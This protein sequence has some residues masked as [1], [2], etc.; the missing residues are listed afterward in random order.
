MP[1]LL[2]FRCRVTLHG[3]CAGVGWL[4]LLASS[5]H[6]LPCCPN[7]HAVCCLL[8]PTQ[9]SLGA[10]APWGGIV[11]LLLALLESYR[12]AALWGVEDAEQRIYPGQRTAA[13]L[14][15]LLLRCLFSCPLF[16]CPL[17]PLP[18]A[19]KSTSCCSP[20]PRP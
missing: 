4:I 1:L 6:P 13:A 18:A 5:T 14:L 20:Q 11:L 7:S 17:L 8:L 9:L 2:M 12:L 19:C 10:L 16:S 3:G 15:K